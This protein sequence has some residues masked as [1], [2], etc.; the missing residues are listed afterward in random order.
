[1]NYTYTLLTLMSITFRLG[2]DSFKCKTRKETSTLITENKRVQIKYPNSNPQSTTLNPCLYYSPM[3]L[4]L[5]II[6]L[7]SDYLHKYLAND[8]DL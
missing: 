7:E 8:I 5:L 6:I 2:T 1:M 4:E 3:I